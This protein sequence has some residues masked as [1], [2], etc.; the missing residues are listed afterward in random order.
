MVAPPGL[1]PWSLVLPD[2]IVCRV[3]G[4]CQALGTKRGWTERQL[5]PPRVGTELQVPR[6]QAAGLESQRGSGG[7]DTLLLP[8]DDEWAVA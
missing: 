1:G 7:S 4:T 5:L 3:P 6:G 8:A 2:V